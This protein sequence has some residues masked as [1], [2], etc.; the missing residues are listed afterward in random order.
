LEPTPI[1]SSLTFVPSGIAAQATEE[2]GISHTLTIFAICFTIVTLI[3]IGLAFF[4]FKFDAWIRLKAAARNSSVFRCP[5]RGDQTAKCELDLEGGTSGDGL[6]DV[7]E[8]WKRYARGFS[9]EQI[10]I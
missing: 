1:P 3:V 9:V 10:L 7:A 4:L 5:T 2:D 6:R 8:T